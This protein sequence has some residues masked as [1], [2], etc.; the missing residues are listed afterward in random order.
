MPSSDPKQEPFEDWLRPYRKEYSRTRARVEGVGLVLRG[1]IG[2]RRVPCGKPT[3]RCRRSGKGH[4]PYYQITW[5]EGGRTKSRFLSPTLVPLYR[6]WLANAH[7]L[8]RI[9]ERMLSISRE[10]ADAV[11]SKEAKRVQARKAPKALRR[12]R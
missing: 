3:C 5:A 7:T 8:D 6:E 10:A 12:P 4:G 2:L 11:R 1:S 9:V